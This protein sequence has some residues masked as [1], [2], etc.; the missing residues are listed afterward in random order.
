MTA[1]QFKTTWSSIENNLSALKEEGLSDLNLSESTIDFLRTS[2]LPSD[3]APF[4]TFCKDTN[5]VFEGINKLTTQ[6]DF[7]E[8]EFG[9]YVVIGSCGNG[10]PIAIDTENND[11]IVLLDHED[12]FSSTFFNSSIFT[13]AECLVVY[14]DFVLTINKE[15]GEDALM[16]SEFSDEQFE[17]L[18][19]QIKAADNNA[20]TEIG[21]WKEQLEME[22]I[23]R[24]DSRREK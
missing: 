15:N 17:K 22:L 14:R 2:G 7:L 12:N 24:Q 10:D 23:L 8:P 13:L 3:A 6:Y 20:F 9:K 16:N 21:F 11:L 5:D 1:E 18:E 19:Q 4:L